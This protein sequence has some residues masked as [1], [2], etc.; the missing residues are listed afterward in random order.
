M[1]DVPDYRIEVLSATQYYLNTE[2]VVSGMHQDKIARAIALGV[3]KEYPAKHVYLYR[4]EEF[5]QSYEG[6]EEYPD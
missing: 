5:I 2:I 3:S 6:G 1:V 4:G